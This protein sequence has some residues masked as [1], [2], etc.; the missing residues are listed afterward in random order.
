M[1]IVINCL[2]QPVRI[3]KSWLGGLID[4]I[5]LPT[6]STELLTYLISKVQLSKK[7]L[8]KADSVGRL[9][10]EHK[11]N[12]LYHKSSLRLPVKCGNLHWT[13]EF[14]TRE[15]ELPTLYMLIPDIVES[16]NVSLY[17]IN[18]HG[19]T[20]LCTVDAQ[21]PQNFILFLNGETRLFGIAIVLTSEDPEHICR[22]LRDKC[23]VWDFDG[24]F[25]GLVYSKSVDRG[26]DPKQSES[27]YTIV[28]TRGTGDDI[29]A[30][31]KKNIDGSVESIL[32]SNCPIAYI[33]K[34]KVVFE[35]GNYCDFTFCDYYKASTTHF[36][37]PIIK[38]TKVECE[39]LTKENYLKYPCNHFNQAL[40]CTDLLV[41]TL[42]TESELVFNVLD[43]RIKE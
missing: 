3:P 22:S 5:S 23:L 6:D 24:N 39:D 42:K 38:A 35:A 40:G 7:E 1:E 13:R 12:K 33:D 15:N 10:S 18:C 28:E 20:K 29:H 17:K 8:K 16:N 30:A 19:H 43:M 14:W 25:I 9:F 36:T 37:W 4:G 21:R 11:S 34:Y 32:T 2:D 41:Q 27:D 31:F 26:N